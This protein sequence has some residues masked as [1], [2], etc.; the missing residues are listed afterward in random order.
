M[1]GRKVHIGDEE[2]KIPRINKRWVGIAAVVIFGLWFLFS[3]FYTVRTEEVG[4][5]RRFGKY[6]RTTLPGLHL[7]LPFGIEKVTKVKIQR[8]FKEE[9]G[10][11][12]LRAGVRTEYAPREYADESLMLTGDLNNAVVEWIVQYRVEDPVKYLFK[13]RRVRDTI[14]AASEAVMRQVAGDRSVDEVVILSRREVALEAQEKMQEI[15][16][17]YDTGIDIVTVKLQDVNPPDPVRPAFNEVNEAK[18]ERERMINQAWEEYNKAIPKAKGE[19]EQ[20][21]RRAEGYALNRVNRAKGDAEKFLAV[22][23]EYSRAKDVTQRRI[24]LET[25]RE[26][27][28]KIGRKYVIDTEQ[29]SLLQLL[30]LEEVG[31]KK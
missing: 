27:L 18:Q 24:Y 4:V 3:T 14:R 29:R 21:I 20:T 13:V 15:L 28:P 9:F 6:V 26:I 1:Q 22:W 25:L 16:D 17:S 19:A 31:G 5:I 2:F 23:R 11:R 8:V 10:F 7:K 30:Q 12:T